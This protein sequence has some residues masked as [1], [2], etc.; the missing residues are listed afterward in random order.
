[1]GVF[2]WILIALLAAWGIGALLLIRRRKKHPRCN[3]CCAD[4]KGCAQKK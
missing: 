1:M 2:D 4:C 3:G